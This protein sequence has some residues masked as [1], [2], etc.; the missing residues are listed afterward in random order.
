MKFIE[1]LC[2]GNYRNKN[3]KQTERKHE[4]IEIGEKKDW[5]K[6]SMNDFVLCMSNEEVISAELE[7][8]CPQT[9]DIL[10]RD[11]VCVCVGC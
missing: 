6:K 3:N 8:N 10:T 5:R 7:E 1:N 4:I 2:Y 9:A 11:F